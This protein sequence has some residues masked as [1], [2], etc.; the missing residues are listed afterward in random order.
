MFQNKTT[1]VG[2]MVG[3]LGGWRVFLTDRRA[4]VLMGREG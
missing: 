1:M 4:K 2:G 3:V